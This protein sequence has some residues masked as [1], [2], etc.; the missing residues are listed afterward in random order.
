[1]KI[2][3]AKNTKNCVIKTKRKF[4][5]YKNCLEAAQIETKIKHFKK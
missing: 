3:K 1:M 5:G 4:E 2:K